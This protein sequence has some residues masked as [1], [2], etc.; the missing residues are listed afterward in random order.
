M[1]VLL[2]FRLKYSIS[3]LKFLLNLLFIS[4]YHVFFI[5]NRIV[6]HMYL[7]C[8]SCCRVALF[9]MLMKFHA[10]PFIL[11]CKRLRGCYIWILD[12]RVDIN[13]SWL[14]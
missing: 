2:D 3:V 10:F 6:V 8:I 13:L 14:V 9:V 5:F 12:S 1:P 7:V 4:Y 11:N